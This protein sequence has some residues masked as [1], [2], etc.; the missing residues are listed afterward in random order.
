M[1]SAPNTLP[2]AALIV[3]EPPVGTPGYLRVLAAAIEDM[4]RADPDGDGGSLGPT[5]MEVVAAA[6][7]VAASTMEQQA[8]SPNPALA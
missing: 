4:L 1:Q 3:S 8:E 2:T 6:L 7:L 5:D